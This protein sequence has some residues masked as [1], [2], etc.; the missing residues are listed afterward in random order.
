MLNDV[1]FNNEKSAFY[2]WNIVLTKKEIPL[3][4]PKT[5][6]V[7][8]KGADGTLDLSEGLTGDIKYNNRTIKLTFSMMDD[9]DYLS[10]ISDLGCYL[11]GKK[12]KFVFTDDD[13]YYYTG[14]AVINSWECVQ[15]KGKIVITIDCEP[16][17]YD[18]FEKV[19]TINLND[20]E[21][22]MVLTN[23]R[24][25]V[26][27]IIEASGEVY[28]TWNNRVY[29]LSEGTQQVIDFILNEGD[30]IVKFNGVGTIKVSYRM[31][32]L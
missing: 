5:S 17:K 30:N 19:M 22:T 10:L 28:L 23:K 4:T 12:T 11:H 26:C 9:K 14:R 15:R 13:G 32:A 8:I 16:Y 29:Q 24:K 7:N 2:D 25:K 18:I 6:L 21:K 27:P 1:I 20:E 31:G 3:P